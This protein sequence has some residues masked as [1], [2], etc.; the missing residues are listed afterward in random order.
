MSTPAP[1]DYLIGTPTTIEWKGQSL[2]LATGAVSVSY[3][4]EYADIMFEVFGSTVYDKALLGEAVSVTIPMG[5]HTYRQMKTIMPISTDTGTTI[6]VGSLAGKSL[7]E[8]AGELKLT[9]QKGNIY[10]FHIAVPSEEGEFEMG[11]EGQAIIEV[12]FMALPDTTKDDGQFLASFQTSPS[13]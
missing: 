12:T 5:E 4:P 6:N 1:Q 10:T 3:S 2:G 11:A 7:R 13:V 9:T 8:Q